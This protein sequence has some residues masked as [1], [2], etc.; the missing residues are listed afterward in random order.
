M[1]RLRMCRGITTVPYISAL[2]GAYKDSFTVILV[3]SFTYH[4]VLY[5]ICD[6]FK[7]LLYLIQVMLNRLLN[8]YHKN[9]P[10]VFIENPCLVVTMKLCRIDYIIYIIAHYVDIFRCSLLTSKQP[11]FAYANICKQ[12]L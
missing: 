12:H 8:K 1:L 9:P 3:S 10:L 2:C 5:S 7:L 11:G 6:Y 4:F